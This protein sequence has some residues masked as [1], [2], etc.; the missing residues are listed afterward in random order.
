VLR[1]TAPLA[2]AA[3]PVATMADNDSFGDPGRPARFCGSPPANVNPR[4][5]ANDDDCCDLNGSVRPGQTET[6]ATPIPQNCPRARG[7]G[8]NCDGVLRYLEN[9][10]GSEFVGCNDRFLPEGVFA[11]CEQ[12]SSV[13]GPPGVELVAADG[14]ASQCGSASVS[15]FIC[16]SDATGCALESSAAPTPCN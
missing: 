12:R 8:Y 13:L 9:L 11:P 3:S 1:A 4:V 5:V 16:V 2:V 6:F 15:Y 10:R 14:N 7:F